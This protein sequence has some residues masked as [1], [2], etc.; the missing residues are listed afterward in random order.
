MEV[1]GNPHAVKGIL[2]VVS[3]DEIERLGGEAL[4]K[5]L[6]KGFADPL[7]AGLVG[8]VVKREHEHGLRAR[9]LAKGCG[10]E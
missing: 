6:R 10:R 1:D 7:Q 9:C 8:G 5:N 2:A 4:A 3:A